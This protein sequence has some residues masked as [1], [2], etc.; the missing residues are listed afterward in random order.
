MTVGGRVFKKRNTILTLMLLSLSMSGCGVKHVVRFEGLPEKP[1]PQIS[2]ELRG[3]WVTRFE[4][5]HTHPDTMKNRIRRTINRI[6][7]TN[8]NA[9]F[10]QVRGQAETL[11]PSPLEPWS[12]LVG[13][14]DPGFDPVRM[15]VEEAHNHDLQ[16]YAYIN[17]MPLWNE[18]SP[19]KDSTHLYFRHGPN[20]APEHS[21]VCFDENHKPMSLDEYYYLNPALPEVKTYLKKVIR[22]FVETYDIDGLHFDRIRYPGAGYVNDPLSIQ[23][24]S[25]DSLEL[26]FSRAEWARS[27]LT[28]LVEDVVTEAMLIKPYLVN[29]AATWG[30]YRT[31][32]IEG[33]EQFGSGYARYYQDAIDWLDRG[34]MDFIVPM[35]Y[36]DIED[37]LPNFDDL[38]MDFIARTSNFQYIYPGI[39]IRPGWIRNGETIR[40]IQL[41]RSQGGK[42]TVMF[43]S[44]SLGK[45]E[46]R[47]LHKIAYAGKVDVPGNSK[48][49]TPEQVVGLRL[50]PLFPDS[51]SGRKVR[52]GENRPSKHTD[53]DGRIGIILPDKPDHVAIKTAN[54][55]VKLNTL[56]WNTPYDYVVQPDSTVERQS[57]WLEFRRMPGDT[58]SSRD[59][60]LLCKTDFPAN[61]WI[62]GDTAKV[63][64]TG[65]F[66]KKINLKRGPNRISARIVS[67]DSAA[68]TYEREFVHIQPDRARKPF[69]LWIDEDS[70]EPKDDV[71][72]L[73][74]DKIRIV[75]KGSRRQTAFAEIHP[76]KQRLRFSR[77]DHYDYS[78]Y[79]AELPMRL[80]KSGRENRITIVIEGSEKN[81]KTGKISTQMKAR[82]QTKAQDEFPLV[83]TVKPNS[84]VSHSLGNVRL[85]SPII[86][87]YGAGVIL[88]TSGKFGGNL[89]IHLDDNTEGYI[90]QENVEELPQETLQPAYYIRSLS[91]T[92]D[93]GMDILYIPYTEPIP[94]S[95]R[96]EPK[97]NRIIVSLYGVQTSSTW[98]THHKGRR[99]IERV[100][101]KQATPE[102]YQVII[103][104]KS[105]KI[106]G[107]DFKPVGS[108]LVFRLKH[109]PSL[110]MQDTCQTLS[111]LK[112][113]IEA[114]HGGDN[115]G[116]VGLSGIF[117]KDLNLDVA[118]KLEKICT[119]N[120]AEILMV[121][122]KDLYI[123][124]VD[125]RDA[126]ESSD[127][128]ML[129]SI[130]ANAAALWGGY[131]RVGGTSTY[132]HNPFWAKF[133][134]IVYNKLLELNLAEFG[135]V[136]SFNYTVTRMSSRPAILVEKAFLSHAEDEEKLARESFRQEIAQKIY[137]GIVEFVEYMITE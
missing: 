53:A 103:N 82:F 101:W 84:I 81:R 105:P 113:A 64:E 87:E 135:V 123:S 91:C 126:V 85:G 20:A 27:Q 24:F 61:A 57:P 51:A 46:C 33:Y 115:L 69:P 22:H 96:P 122:D 7:K 14:K 119:D 104:L 67:G 92:S 90:R 78:L 125:K 32:D 6:E 129:V 12:K 28:D 108:S 2:K 18:E 93:G 42:G 5:A 95:I 137:E 120:G 111:G 97:R 109:P 117:E 134:E 47:I 107:Y 54:A 112:L 89:R 58:T 94:Y 3:V 128:H 52:I 132:Y 41:V 34:I 75:F 102:T 10:F 100:E 68:V 48:H 114:G 38:W 99:V 8:F 44:S 74:N 1:I 63:Y 45:E 36:W 31:D 26:P 83:K 70:I 136:G 98:I 131:L 17:L 62:E 35:I 77:K 16:F 88:K 116:A 65:I 13:Y 55:S 71:I 30:L 59:F 110:C 60:H 40:Q 29:S 50:R 127:A 73:R 106:W 124:L 43:S 4:W 11:Y 15:A 39:R 133:A 49:V 121:R 72:L 76:G 21:W 79:Q 56:R 23:R 80:L 86:A 19:P 130:H 66:F 37:P 118:R 9:V 25:A